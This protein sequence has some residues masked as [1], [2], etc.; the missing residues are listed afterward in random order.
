MKKNTLKKCNEIERYIT[1]NYDLRYNEVKNEIEV[2]AKSDLIYKTA[3]ERF[4]NSL[5]L[6]VSENGFTSKSFIDIYLKSD[7]IKNYNPFKEYFENLPKWDQKTQYIKQLCSTLK[8]HNDDFV[9]WSLSRWVIALVASMIK[10]EAINHQL[11]VLSGKQGIGKSTWIRKIIPG[12][13]KS[14]L[15]TGSINPNNKDTFRHLSSC[16]LIDLD[17]LTNLNKKETGSLKE[18]ITKSLI[19]LRVPYGRLYE[20]FPRRASF[21]GSINDRQFLYDSTGNR[22]FL[23]YDVEEILSHDIDINLVLAEAYFKFKRGDKYWFDG[24]DIDRINKNNESFRVIDAIEEEITN[25]LLPTPTDNAP[26]Y[27]KASEIYYRLF[28]RIPNQSQSQKVGRLLSKMSFIQKSMRKEGNQPVK[29]WAIY[30]R[31]ASYNDEGA[32]GYHK[33]MH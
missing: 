26:E 7:R 16:M 23:C 12:E 14:Y 17:E 24:E 28:G 21:I 5:K 6:E 25:R 22:R 19:K 10:N 15:Y 2:K 20:D 31:N 29:M 3:N 1:E 4:I 32:K 13:L 8:T 18:L 9:E 11:P 33:Y 30:D 27:L